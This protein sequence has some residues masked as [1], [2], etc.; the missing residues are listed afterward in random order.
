MVASERFERCL[1]VMSQM[2]YLCSTL[3]IS[4]LVLLNLPL[5]AYNALRTWVLPSFEVAGFLV[6]E[7]ILQTLFL[8]RLR[9]GA[10]CALCYNALPTELLSGGVSVKMG[11]EPMTL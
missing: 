8:L 5:T 9:K 3:A 2:S 4:N 6:W 1:L 10:R 7:D 11:L